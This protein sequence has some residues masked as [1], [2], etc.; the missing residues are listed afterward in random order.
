MYRCAN[1]LFAYC[2]GKPEW[3]KP[4]ESLGVDKYPGGGHCKL[5][6]ESCGRHQTL[7]QQLDGGINQLTREET[8]KPKR[9]KRA[10][11]GT[12]S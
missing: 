2:C 6:P 9:Q 4:P 3:G 1:D 5:N 11:T 7:R 12:R 10:R 8:G